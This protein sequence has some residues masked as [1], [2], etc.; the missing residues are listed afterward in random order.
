[1]LSLGAKRLIGLGAIIAGILIVVLGVTKPNPAASTHVYWAEFDSAQGLGAIG[2]DIRV[3]GVNVGSIGAVERVGDDARIELI[4]N[5]DIPVKTDARAD[6]RPHTLFE[7]SSFIDLA[8]GSPSA[9]LLEEEGT[10]A[11][12]RTSNYITLDEALRILRPEVRESLGDL[13]ET[14]SET[15]QGEAIDGIQETL[16]N[17]PELTRAL[18]GPARSLQGP[19]GD[20]LGG[21]ISGMSQ[22]VDAVA[23]RERDLIP[24]AQRL[25]RTTAAL[26]VDS[27]V[28]LDATLAAL[29]GALQEL[30][31]GAPELTGLVD[32]LD[33]FAGQVNPALPDFTEAVRQGTPLFA[34]TIPVLRRATPLISDLRKVSGRLADASPT[35][36]KLVR[37]LDPVTRDFG[38]SV[39]PVLLQDSRNG[40][41]TFEQLLTTFTA[42]D[43][44][45]RPYQTPSQ[46]PNGSGHLWNIG[47]YADPS[48]PFAGGFP[49]PSPLACA[50]V[51]AVSSDAADAIRAS[52]GCQ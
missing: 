7:G 43:G 10:I 28:P 22:T 8:P 4:L 12:E 25:N 38:E 33:T 47:T 27:S 36:T 30:N 32:R 46:N 44:V 34:R 19:G 51:S 35:L 26:T 2:R 16:K 31:D 41:P 1:M 15:L 49:A 20:E 40:P 18:K 37:K 29:P 14:G 52:G 13:A 39:L 42:A 9:E 21:A 11:I 6:M 45:F 23:D 50:R 17:S 5:E 24:L 3:G 48:G